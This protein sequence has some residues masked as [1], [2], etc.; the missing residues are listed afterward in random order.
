MSLHC[1]Q[2]SNDINLHG[3]IHAL[4]LYQFADRPNFINFYE[5]RIKRTNVVITR[6]IAVFSRKKIFEFFFCSFLNFQ[7]IFTLRTQYTY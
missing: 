1:Y 4:Y 2:N 5:L 6:E 3:N 7:L